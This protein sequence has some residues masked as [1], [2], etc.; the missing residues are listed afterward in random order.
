MAG[1]AGDEDQ[2]LFFHQ[3]LLMILTQRFDG[4]KYQ[5]PGSHAK[6]QSIYNYKPFTIFKSYGW[7][8]MES[9]VI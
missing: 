1:G 5:K 6:A 7:G 8:V 2:G 3:L 4:L 9:M